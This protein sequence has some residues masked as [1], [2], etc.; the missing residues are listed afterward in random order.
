MKWSGRT[1]RRSGK[2]SDTVTAIYRF[3]LRKSIARLSEIEMHWSLPSMLGYLRTW[4]ATQ[5]FIA[6]NGK[7]PVT[8]S[9]MD[10]ARPGETQ[11]G[12][13]ASSGR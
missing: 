5:R 10:L 13:G 2:W 4:S 1:G 12:N 11:S 3:P 9:P 7:D 8:L 6:A